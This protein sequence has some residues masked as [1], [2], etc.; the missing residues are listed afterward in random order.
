MQTAVNQ[1]ESLAAEMGVSAADLTSFVNCL[2]IWTDKGLS[3]EE[4]I[5]RHQQQMN[6]FANNAIE[7]ARS[8]DM[9]GL[10]VEWFFP[11]AA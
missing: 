4:A 1:I 10:V 11:I 6:R 9:R 8:P 2:R 3:I 7:L 5:E